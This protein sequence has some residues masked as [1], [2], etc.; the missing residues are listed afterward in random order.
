[1]RNAIVGIAF[2]FAI[3]LPA[4][5]AGMPVEQSLFCQIPAQPTY[6]GR[7]PGGTVDL[8]LYANGELLWG[9]TPVDRRTFAE[10]LLSASREAKKPIFNVRAEPDTKFST[11]MPVLL[12]I[13]KSGITTVMVGDT[14]LGIPKATK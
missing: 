7:W 4:N 5:A 8:V 3:A 6:D 1:M 13:Q 9:G 14:F 12:Q 2:I 10:Y 11:L